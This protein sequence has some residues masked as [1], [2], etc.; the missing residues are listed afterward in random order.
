VPHAVAG[1]L[2]TGSECSGS[3]LSRD[4]E[5]KKERKG[6]QVYTQKIISDW[7]LPKTMKNRK[8]DTFFCIKFNFQNM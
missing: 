6:E 7:F 2:F 4:D 3:E 5:R 8:L 1:L